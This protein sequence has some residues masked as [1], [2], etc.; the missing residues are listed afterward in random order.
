MMKVPTLPRRSLMTLRISQV[1]A[2]NTVALQKEFSG[3]RQ[4][5]SSIHLNLVNFISSFSSDLSITLTE[6]L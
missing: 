3:L 4:Q 6:I 2:C 5:P 1:T